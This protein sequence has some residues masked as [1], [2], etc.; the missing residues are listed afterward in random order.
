M[1]NVPTQTFSFT[2]SQLIFNSCRES[3]D[4]GPI[5]TWDRQAYMTTLRD[6]STKSFDPIPRT[7]HHNFIFANYGGS[8]AVDNDDGSSW[9]HI[10]KNLFYSAEGFKMDYGGHD[11]IYEDNLIMTY[12]YDGMQCFHLDAF[13]NGPSHTYRRNRCL[14]G[15][16]NYMDSGCGDPSCATPTPYPE[17]YVHV[18][19]CHCD[20]P[21]LKM[22]SNEY[23]TQEGDAVIHCGDE[24]Y[25]LEELPEKFGLEEGSTKSKF[26]DEATIVKWAQEMINDMRLSRKEAAISLQVKI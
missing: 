21:N 5:N 3:G 16:G 8:Q 11:S 20:E 19:S 2:L 23:Y 10:Y 17:D 25:D 18:G 9:F 1:R 13:S 26:P 7:I 14:I 4:H 24:E 15:L 22:Y 6:G 12:P